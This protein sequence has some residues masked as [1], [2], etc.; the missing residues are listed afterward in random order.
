MLPAVKGLAEEVFVVERP[1]VEGLA[2]AVLVA[3]EIAVEG[4]AVREPVET[5]V[6]EEFAGEKLAAAVLVVLDSVG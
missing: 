3:Q 6:G 1:V 4:P 5:L 2:V